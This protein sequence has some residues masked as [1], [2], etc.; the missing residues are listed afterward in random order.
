MTIGWSRLFILG[1][2]VEIFS[3]QKGGGKSCPNKTTISCPLS[4]PAERQKGFKS[5]RLERFFSHLECRDHESTIACFSRWKRRRRLREPPAVAAAATTTAKSHPVM[6]VKCACHCTC[7][8][9]WEDGGRSVL[10][11][12]R[13]QGRRKMS[14]PIKSSSLLNK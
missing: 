11:L 14:T 9:K 4:R 7:R 5:R 3:T 13:C 10:I 2:T 8:V 6:S 12:S 1:K